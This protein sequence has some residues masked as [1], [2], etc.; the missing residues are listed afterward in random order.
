MNTIFTKQTV[1]RVI[2][3][4]TREIANLRPQYVKMPQNENEIRSVKAAFYNRRQF[5]NVIGCIDGTHIPIQSPGGEHAEI[6]R[7]RKSYFS[8]NV[9]V[10][11]DS[12]L[13]IRDI[14]ARWPGSTHDSTMFNSSLICVSLEGN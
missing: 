9:Q 6:F 13:M 5:P 8:V 7:N 1:C 11:C 4:V 2:Q 12:T 10:V 3:K 14:V